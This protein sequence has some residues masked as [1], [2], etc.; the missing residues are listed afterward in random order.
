MNIVVQAE[1]TVKLRGI[2]KIVKWIFRLSKR[3]K[4]TVAQSCRE[5]EQ[6]LKE[7]ED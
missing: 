7:L 6:K 5:L 2:E 1:L 4:I 3:N